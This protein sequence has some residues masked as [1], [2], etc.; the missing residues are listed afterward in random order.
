LVG[1]ILGKAPSPAKATA[2]A[3]AYGGCPYSVVLTTAGTLVIGVYSLP[4]EHHWWLQRLEDDPKGTLGLE[5]AEVLFT[6]EIEA[7]SPWTR[8]EVK[9]E[10]ELAPCGADCADCHEYLR[11][12]GGCP[13]TTYHLEIA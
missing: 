2:I 11:I 3:E 12:C 5:G 7:Y 9:S 10:L 8:G 4:P 1:V 6:T 13:A